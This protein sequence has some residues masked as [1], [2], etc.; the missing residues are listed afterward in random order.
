L[1]DTS[2]AGSGVFSV[3][4]EQRPEGWR[5]VHDHT[6]ADP[7]DAKAPAGLP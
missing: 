7:G 5:I 4:L 3:M 6:S 1:T 2:Q